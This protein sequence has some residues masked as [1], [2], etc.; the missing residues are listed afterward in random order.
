MDS[1]IQV[2]DHIGIFTQRLRPMKAF[3][4]GTLGFALA[5]EG[6][7]S[8]KIMEKIFDFA[9]DCHFVKLHKNGFMVEL[10][11]PV[12]TELHTPVPG[13]RGVNHWGYCVADRESFV[14]GL[15]RNGH[16][17]AEIDRNGRTVYFV[18]DPDGN[19]IEIRDC[20]R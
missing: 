5:G 20:A 15:R 10:F 6:V 9:H 4:T 16:E 11:A 8:K 12:S 17:I 3:Y 2:C 13:A 19:R 14:E 1:L 18:D 7:L